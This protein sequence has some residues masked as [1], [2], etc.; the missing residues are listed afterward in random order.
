[1]RASLRLRACWPG[2]FHPFPGIASVSVV[3]TTCCFPL[4]WMRTSPP[5]G[6]TT[7]ISLKKQ[8]SIRTRSLT[9]TTS[10]PRDS[11]LFS[12]GGTRKA[13]KDYPCVYTR[14][15][16]CAGFVAVWLST[17]AFLETDAAFAPSFG[18]LC[19]ICLLSL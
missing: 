6:I 2:M 13:A 18:L 3:K 17:G 1:M 4:S 5:S 16:S 10:C 8:I 7:A 15:V 11:L 19:H 9:Q 14:G 12:K